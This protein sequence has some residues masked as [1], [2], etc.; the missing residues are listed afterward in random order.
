MDLLFVFQLVFTLTAIVLGYAVVVWNLQRAA[1][2]EEAEREALWRR[3]ALEAGLEFVNGEIGDEGLAGIA[4]VERQLVGLWRGAQVRVQRIDRGL[5]PTRARIDLVPPLDL[6][7]HVEILRGDPFIPKVLTGD[8]IFDEAFL[9]IGD[10]PLEVSLLLT[11]EVRVALLALA[12]HCPDVIVDRGGIG[13][14][15]NDDLTDPRQLEEI[16]GAMKALTHGLIEA[17]GDRVLRHDLEG[18]PSRRASARRAL[19]G[20]P[21][22]VHQTAARR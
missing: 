9:V 18:A 6:N 19:V 2:R 22:A 8:A 20:Q 4:R 16:L 14:S 3:A 5:P 12:S 11:H 1:E 17:E 15:L 13:W 10:S 7:L 21:Q